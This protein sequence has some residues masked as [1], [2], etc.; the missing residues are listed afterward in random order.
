MLHVASVAQCMSGMHHPLTYPGALPH[1]KHTT[2]QKHMRLRMWWPEGLTTTPTHAAAV[3]LCHAQA[4]CAPARTQAPALSWRP[5]A[6]D[7]VYER[8]EQPPFLPLRN[9]DAI[10]DAGIRP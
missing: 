2:V 6:V 4:I 5:L 8:S 9:D 1:K 3:P 10:A 7:R